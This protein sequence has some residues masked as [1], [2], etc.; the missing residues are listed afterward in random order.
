MRTIDELEEIIAALADFYAAKEAR[1]WLQSP[2]ALLSGA[3]PVDLV[4]AGQGGDV[5][6][7]VRQMQD[8]V[9]L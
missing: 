7:L 3:R 2:Q 8:A 5:L 4:R 1:Q 6:R 9:Y